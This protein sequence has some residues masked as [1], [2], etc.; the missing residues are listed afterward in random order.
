M[1]RTLS[2]RYAG[3]E[4]EPRALGVELN[5]ETLLSGRIVVQGRSAARAGGAGGHLGRVP[6]IWGS[7]FVRPVTDLEVVASRSLADDVCEA[8]R[9]RFQTA[10]QEAADVTRAAGRPDG[11]P[12]VPARAATTGTSGRAKACCRPSTRSGRRQT[13]IASYAPA[14]AG[15]ADAY[16]AASYYGYLP[17]AEAMPRAH[18]AAE[19]ALQLDPR[20]AEAHAVL[21]MS[22]MFFEWDW[23]AAD[24]SRSGGEF[25]ERSLTAQVY[26]APFPGVPGRVR[27]LAREGG[28]GRTHRPAV[29]AGAVSSVAWGL[30]HTGDVEGAEAQLHRMLGVDPEFFEAL[31]LLSHIAEARQDVELATA[32]NRRWFPRMGSP[33]PTPSRCSPRTVNRG[34]PATG[35]AIWSCSKRE[36]A[37]GATRRPCSRRPSTRCWGKKAPRSTPSNARTTRTCRC[38]PSPRW[39]C[40]SR[41]CAGTRDSR[42]CC[43]GCG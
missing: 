21:G 12:R 15:L 17:A 39:T 29:A 42:P 31:T 20:L 11:L 43:D 34:G 2:F 23:A 7:R 37:R 13:P 1:P 19:L 14:Y 35:A 3:R 27:G 6:Q 30:L 41:R 24:A 32:Y 25:G 4:G 38:W 9:G 22:A 40:T 28:T 18:H 10:D 33:K 36:P 16:G 8:L 5:A 26:R